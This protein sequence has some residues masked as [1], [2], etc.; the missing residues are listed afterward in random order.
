MTGRHNFDVVSTKDVHIGRVVGLRIDDVTMPGGGTST[1]EVVEHLGAVAVVAIDE[2]DNV[3]LVYQYRHPMGRRL[4]E[5]PAGLLDVDNEDPVD[6]ARRELAEEAGLAARE[7]STLVDVAASPGFTDEVVRVYL[8]RGLSDADRDEPHE[9]EEADLVVRR[10]PLD[11]A[12]H[13]VLVGEIVNGSAVAGLLAAH[14][15]RSGAFDARP[16]RTAWRDRPTRF[17]QRR[18]TP[19][20]RT[21]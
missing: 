3:V 2:D 10:V 18:R 13:M 11:E 4:W 6:T 16:A 19:D 5:I 9:D 21:G 14:T 15:V 1:R 7:W 8:A 20:G 17:A 12:I